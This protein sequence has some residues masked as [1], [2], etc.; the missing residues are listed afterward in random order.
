MEP[1]VSILIPA[2]NA[3]DWI[4]D[5]INSA[6]AQTWR[7]KEI[8]IVDD[9]SADETLRVAQKFASN[10]VEVVAQPNQ[11]A[12]VARN[13]AL[14]LCQGDYI[15]WLDADDLL[16]PDKIARQLDL[17]ASGMS[18]RTLLS[19]AWG[20]F[21]YRPQKAAF[22]PTSLWQDL[23]PV[24]CLVL[25]MG[26]GAWM[27]IESWLVSRE[28]AELAGPWD[29]R[30]LRDNDGEYFSRIICA[31][32][33]IRFVPTARSYVRDGCFGSISCDFSVSEKK[34]E[35]LFLSLSLQ[36]DHLRSLE[37]SDRTRAACL[38]L[39]QSQFIWFYPER[40]SIVKQARQAASDLGGQ[41]EPPEPSWKYA[42]LHRLFGWGL[43][44][45]VSS[46]MRK[47]KVGLFRSWDEF[48]FHLER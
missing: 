18:R 12:C 40:E 46:A 9:G 41:L 35:S 34:L 30:L 38:R 6:L 2:Y 24:D 7:R 43:T 32:D 14:S 4:A 1:L 8:I 19:S 21:Y 33:G 13:K 47:T 42:L 26:E 11:G 23:Q 45:R 3:Q 27:A 28:L 37:D 29:T 36:T 5:S 22:T 48:L 31:S 25:R 16:A 44:K 39:L 17:V 15:Q 10:L 20:R